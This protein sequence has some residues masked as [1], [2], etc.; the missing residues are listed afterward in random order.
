MYSYKDRLRAILLYIQIDERV[1]L[2]FRQLG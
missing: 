2:T 1:G